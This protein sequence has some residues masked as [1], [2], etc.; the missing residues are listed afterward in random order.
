RRGGRG[1]PFHAGERRVRRGDA[2]G[3]AGR[4]RG[5]GPEEEGGRRPAL[6]A[7]AGS[8]VRK[9]ALVALVLCACKAGPQAAPASTGSGEDATRYYPLAVGNSWTYAFHGSNRRETIQIVGRD[10]AWFIDDHRGRLRY[11]SDGVRDADRYLLRT[12]LATG[13]KWSAVENLVVQRFEVVSMD[14]S[15]VTEAGTFIRWASSTTPTTC[16]SS[17]E[18]AA[19]SSAVSASRTARWSAAASSFRSSRRRCST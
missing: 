17:R 2:P 3:G 14:A 8:P 12:P 9:F 5:P 15:T 19:I 6:A 4:L 13:A 11:E 10:G 16:A 1:L 7:Q 18:R